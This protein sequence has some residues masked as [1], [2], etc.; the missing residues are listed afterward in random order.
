VLG[1]IFN[2]QSNCYRT[3]QVT[4]IKLEEQSRHIGHL[5]VYGSALEVI[6]K[7]TNEMPEAQLDLLSPIPEPAI[8]PQLRFSTSGLLQQ[9][10]N[11]IGQLRTEN[12]TYRHDYL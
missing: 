8:H 11:L 5:A 7:C 4:A 2:R 3:L 1:N 6:D 12:G 9:A 10:N